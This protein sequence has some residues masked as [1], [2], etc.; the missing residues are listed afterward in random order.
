LLE[1]TSTSPEETVKIGQILS[2][3]LL[4]GDLV[5]LNG[6]LGAGKTLLVK[7][8]GQGL[9]IDPGAVTSPTF[10]IINEYEGT[11]FPLYH[12]DLYRLESDLDLEQVGYE[13]YFYGAGVTVVEWGDLFRHHL[14][15]ERL[16]I[17][18]ESL[19]TEERKLTVTGRGGRGRQVEEQLRGL[20]PCTS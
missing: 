16:D 10:S 18:L 6:T 1:L 7:G 19:G 5:N 20:F 14:P 3:C 17:E 9:G 15:E 8:I 11:K 12:F 4:P 2:Q 13:E